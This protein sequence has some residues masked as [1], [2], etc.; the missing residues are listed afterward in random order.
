M[1]RRLLDLI[2]EIGTIRR[3]WLTRA[4]RQEVRRI[5]DL[6]RDDLPEF[7]ETTVIGI[8]AGQIPDISPLNEGTAT[9]PKP[10][11]N[12]TLRTILRSDQPDNPVA[13]NIGGSFFKDR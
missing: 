9:F 11:A 6:C 12:T 8:N 1:I 4:G 3:S 2:G 5:L 7:S 10:P 13:E